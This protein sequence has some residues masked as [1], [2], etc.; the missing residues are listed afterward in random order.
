MNFKGVEESAVEECLVLG[1]VD[2]RSVTIDESGE[3]E[4]HVA[5]SDLEKAK[6][7]L[8]DLGVADYDRAE[9]TMYP[10]EW[11]EVDEEAKAKL[12]AMLDELDEA[13]DVQAV[14]TN[15]DNI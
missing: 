5:P 10:N 6:E 4:V 15:V 8:K 13:E 7:L 14:Y 9:T 11:I 2:V 12:K 3:I 1:D